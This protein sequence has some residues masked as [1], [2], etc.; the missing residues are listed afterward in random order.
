MFALCMN[1]STFRVCLTLMYWSTL[2]RKPSSCTPTVYYS[3]ALQELVSVILVKIH[4][5]MH[6]NRKVDSLSGWTLLKLLIISKNCSNISCSELNFVQESQWAHMPIPLK[7]GARGLERLPSLKYYYVLKRESRFTLRLNDAKNTHYIKV[8][9]KSCWT[10]NLSQKSYW[11]YMPVSPGVELRCC[12][13][14][15][16]S[17]ITLYWNGKADSL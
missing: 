6:W 8:L 1:R 17:N 7:S 16:V 14:W 9:N 13:D 3:S 15:Y 2:Y 11:A 10:L 12:K 4:I 5:I